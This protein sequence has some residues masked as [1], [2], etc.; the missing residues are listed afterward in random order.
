MHF[1]FHFRSLFLPSSDCA[2]CSEEG[3]TKESQKTEEAE[4]AEEA[5]AEEEE[6]ERQKE[7][8]SPVEGKLWRP[9]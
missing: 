8:Q 4:E 7:R 5:E 1:R 3:K 2:A 6:K 9:R